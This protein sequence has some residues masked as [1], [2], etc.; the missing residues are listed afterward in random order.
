MDELEP[1]RKRGRPRSDPATRNVKL[2]LTEV[3]IKLLRAWGRGDVS[4]GLRWLVDAMT[5]FIRRRER[6]SK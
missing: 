2:R 3:Q 6:G 4:A 5:P 1:R